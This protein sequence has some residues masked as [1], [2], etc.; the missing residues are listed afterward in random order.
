MIDDHDAVLHPHLVRVP[1]FRHVDDSE[2]LGLPGIGDID[3]GGA[4][5]RPHMAD[6]ERGAVD[7]DLA[8]ARAIDMRNLLGLM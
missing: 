7:P 8:T 5:R 2:H 6:I 4:A 3:D 1:A